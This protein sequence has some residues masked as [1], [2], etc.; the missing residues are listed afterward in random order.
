MTLL[1]PLGLIGL[2]GI[3]ILIIIYIIKPNYQQKL[4][5]STYIWKLSLKYR[6]KKVPISK[7]RNILIIICQVLILTAAAMILAKP[8]QVL[9]HKVEHREVIAIIDSS[10][11]MRS[12]GDDGQTRFERALDN[13]QKLS[14]EVLGA[15]GIVSVIIADN[16]PAFLMEKCS[17][18]NK[19]ELTEELDKLL[20]EDACSYGTSNVESAFALCEALLDDNPDTEIFLY[21][22]TKYSY[23]PNTAKLQVKDMAYR[24][25][26]A[27]NGGEWN[28]AILDAYTV[29]ED[30]FYTLY[31]D[32]ASYGKERDVTVNVLIN[33]ANFESEESSGVTIDLSYTV[34]CS[35]DATTRIIF[36][37]ED[38]YQEIDGDEQSTV[39]YPLNAQ[40]KFFSY[41]DIYIYIQED[42]SFTGDNSFSIFGGD[43]EIIKVLYRSKEPN[44]FFPA[45]MQNLRLIYQDKWDF[46][47][48]ELKT[49][50]KEPDGGFKGYDFY[51]FEHEMPKN[52]PTDGIVFLCNPD[53]APSGADFRVGTD[54]HWGGQ[55]DYMVAENEDHP[56]LQYMDAER[57]GITMCKQ[58]AFGLDYETLLTTSDGVPTLAVCN[59]TDKKVIVTSFSV[60]FSTLAV[61][62]HISILMYNIFE[63]FIPSTVNANAFEVQEDIILNA[64]SEQLYVTRDGSNDQVWEFNTFPA[65]LN[66][67]IPGAYVL[68]QTTF[69]DKLITEKIY[70]RIP[71]EE[72]NIWATAD[73]L[74][75]PY[76]TIDDTSHYN[77]LLVYIAGAMVA[78]LFLEWWLQSRAS[79]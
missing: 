6:K 4:I 44:P 51:F 58:L 53:V 47:L 31:V 24:V 17:S 49:T 54:K 77:D 10:A 72:S 78:I 5:S 42:D 46:W 69:A 3:I 20:D 61:S 76:K 7:L 16:T 63:Y 1:A 48:T 71:K 74:E 75:N 57:L 32:V 33:G 62:E 11:S 67:E 52:L 21:T 79:V 36:I 25:E 30:N 34:R 59:Q 35:R 18:E 15:N 55:T 26:G 64:R 9:S 39:Y 50:E 70:V 40:E 37:K 73:A 66:V 14:D 65:T 27:E 13:V 22:D 41:K 68:Q 38:L 12:L 2:I 45:V 19:I 29:L 56:I 8:A 60:H 43:K 23:V 28:A